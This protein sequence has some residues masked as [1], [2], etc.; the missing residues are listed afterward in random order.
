MLNAKGGY[1]RAQ[2]LGAPLPLGSVEP[3]HQQQEFLSAI[4]EGEILFTN[5][6]PKC[7]ANRAQHRIAGVMPMIIVEPL[8]MI[9]VDHRATDRRGVLAKRRDLFVEHDLEAASIGEARQ[10]IDHRHFPQCVSQLQIVEREADIL[11]QHLEI[12]VGHIRPPGVALA[13]EIEHAQGS[14]LRSQRQAERFGDS[15][16]FPIDVIARD[17]DVIARGVMRA[18]ASQRPATER[19]EFGS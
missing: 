7:C 13:L 14:V 1:S 4:T 2:I 10:G 16:I 11:R 19:R 8:E 17:I 18:A 5:G 15:A 6:L 12:D 3:R 9:D